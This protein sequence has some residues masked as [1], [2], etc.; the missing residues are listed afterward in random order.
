MTEFERNV[1]TEL[2]AIR[3][4]LERLFPENATP[5]EIKRLMEGW[6]RPNV[7]RLGD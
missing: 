5:E 4:V 3:R 7:Q 6:A 2:K 1:V